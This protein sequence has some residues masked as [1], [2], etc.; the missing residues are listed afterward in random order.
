LPEVLEKI[1]HS[2]DDELDETIRVATQLIEPA[3]IVFMGVT[4]GGLALAL[5]LPIFSISNVLSG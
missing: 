5:L 4:I 3:M 2:A 1:A